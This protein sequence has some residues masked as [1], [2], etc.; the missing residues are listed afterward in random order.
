VGIAEL[1]IKSAI[2]YIPYNSNYYQEDQAHQ[3][4]GVTGPMCQQ[5]KQTATMLENVGNSITPLP[6][7]RLAD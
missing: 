5:L 1:T 4:D 2:Y 7:D 3:I 6:M